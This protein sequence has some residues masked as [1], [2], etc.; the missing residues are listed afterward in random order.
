MQVEHSQLHE[1][2]P[3]SF[4]SI[5]SS[6]LLVGGSRWVGVMSYTDQIIGN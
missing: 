4:Y 1:N 5:V 3:S 2:T 6:F